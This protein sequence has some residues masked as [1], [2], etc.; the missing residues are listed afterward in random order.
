MAARPPKETERE[1]DLTATYLIGQSG[2]IDQPQFYR[3]LCGLVTVVSAI[4]SSYLGVHRA[5]RNEAGITDFS[6]LEP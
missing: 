3:P 5:R 2:T 6:G 1:P 4:H